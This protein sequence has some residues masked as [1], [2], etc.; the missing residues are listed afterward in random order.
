MV[1]DIRRLSGAWQQRRSRACWLACWCGQL[2]SGLP[3]GPRQAARRRL[4]W[5]RLVQDQLQQLASR[6][7]QA[8]CLPRP[9]WQSIRRDPPESVAAEIG[10]PCPTGPCQSSEKAPSRTPICP[11]PTFPATG[12]TAADMLPPLPVGTETSAKPAE[13]DSTKRMTMRPLATPSKTSFPVLILWTWILKGLI[14]PA[15]SKFDWGGR[16][17]S[18]NRLPVPQESGKSLANHDPPGGASTAAGDPGE[19]VAGA[20]TH[21]PDHLNTQVVRMDPTVAA[22]TRMTAAEDRLAQR[23][24]AIETERMPLHVFLEMISGLGN[25]PIQLGSEEL[26]M[27]AISAAA[28][29]SV[30]RQQTSLAEVL[31]EALRPLHLD[32]RALGPVVMI[33]W[34]GAEKVREIDYPIADLVTPE[35]DAA[36]LAEWIHQL[37]APTS[38]R[39]AGGEGDLQ[40]AGNTLHI[41]QS[42]RVQYQV[43]CFLERLRLVRKLKPR[44]RYPI[45]RL[46]VE[47]VLQQLAASLHGQA[48]FTFSRYTPLSEI[49]SF[50]QQQLGLAL[51]VDWSA[52]LDW[53]RQPSAQGGKVSLIGPATYTRGLRGCRSTMGPGA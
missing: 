9:M 35:T 42:Q 16:R 21:S 18:L 17:I 38:W 10:S 29:V 46:S 48:R 4:P 52:V 27:A 8:T 19:Q 33:H 44:S 34:P 11:R 51:L 39:A 1:S 14:W 43:L 36:Q 20:R 37:V 25:V 32:Y 41:H 22:P 3:I 31:H 30:R 12:E 7:L 53:V 23:L 13:L 15:W 6:N 49:F 45:E 24:A 2:E 26:R 50:W 5:R 40:I 47:P 28:P